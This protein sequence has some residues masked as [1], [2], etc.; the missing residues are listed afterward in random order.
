MKKPG[1]SILGKRDYADEINSSPFSS[2]C[3]ILLNPLSHLMNHIINKYSYFSLPC[4]PVSTPRGHEPAVSTERTSRWWR[5]WGTRSAVHTKTNKSLQRF[6]KMSVCD[7]LLT[8]LQT[9][10]FLKIVILFWDRTVICDLSFNKYILKFTLYK[11]I[12]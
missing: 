7:V 5:W 9:A 6:W 10:Q 3:D 8:K 11:E 12:K 2:F 4:L 1:C